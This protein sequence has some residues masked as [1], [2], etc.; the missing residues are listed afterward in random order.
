M[1]KILILKSAQ[2]VSLEKKDVSTASLIKR[3][4]LP[5]AFVL[6]GG[7]VPLFSTTQWQN[8]TSKTWEAVTQTWD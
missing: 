8:I 2:S 4:I 5:V 7:V 6:G 3:D 1:G